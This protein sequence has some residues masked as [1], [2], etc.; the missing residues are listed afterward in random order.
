V[1]KKIVDTYT[2]MLQVLVGRD[3]FESGY[4]VL[5]RIHHSVGDGL[6]L[7][8]LLMKGLNQMRRHSL[9][10]QPAKLP[11]L[12]SNQGVVALFRRRPHPSS[13]RINAIITTI[14]ALL[15]LPATLLY[16][17]TLISFKNFSFYSSPYLIKP[18]PWCM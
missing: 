1:V 4:P 14:P 2:Y 10:L 8:G 7:L 18:T 13:N 6:A 5:F 17:V 12:K 16:Q 11:P 3:R 9:P 15:S